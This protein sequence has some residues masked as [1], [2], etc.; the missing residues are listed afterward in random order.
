M[1]RIETFGGA[2]GFAAVAAIAWVP[3]GSVVAPF[4]GGAPALSFYMVAVVTAYVAALAAG[5]PAAVRLVAVTLVLGGAAL[6]AT[7]SVGELALA[8]AVVVSVLRSGIVFGPP[9][10]RSMVAELVLI[11]GGLM[12][13]RVLAAAWPPVAGVVAL[14]G[15]FLVQSVYFLLG[16]MDARADAPADAFETAYRR[17]VELLERP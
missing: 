1:K 2:V 14:W 4:T 13:A 17:A 15:F 9:T 6:L 5:R 7:R 10:A 12:L 11:G 16:D 3:W 8:L